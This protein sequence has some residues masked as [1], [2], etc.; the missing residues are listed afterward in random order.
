MEKRKKS[1]LLM[2][3]ALASSVLFSSCIGS[4]S[5]S[6]KLLDWNRNIESKFVNELVFI[7]F[8]IVPVYE[9][10]IAAD[11][12]IF[13]SIEF[14]NGENPVADTGKVETVDTK[15]GVYTVETK[16]DGYRIQKEGEEKSI[17]LVFDSSD[18]SWSIEAEGESTKLLRFENDDEVVMFLPDGQEMNVELSRAGVLAFKQVVDNYTHYAAR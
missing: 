14:W 1:N 7:A 9:I 17:D 16:A 2:V 10:S 18:K 11:A 6:N 12:L 5:L 15:N 3:A 4:F 8:W 13:N